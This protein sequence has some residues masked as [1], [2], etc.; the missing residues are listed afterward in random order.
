MKLQH[1]TLA[2]ALLTAG[3]VSNQTPE[4]RAAARA[5]FFMG[6]A[7][8]ANQ[9]NYNAAPVVPQQVY[10]YNLP[11]RDTTHATHDYGDTPEVRNGITQSA[12]S[13]G[14]PTG[15]PT[16]NSKVG[17]DGNTWYEFRNS[18]GVLFWKTSWN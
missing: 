3:C 18:A 16:G 1:L 17:L 11:A 13:S 7:Q 4:Q 10:Q 9:Y 8:G 5:A 14:F 15:L 2:A 12:A 6:L